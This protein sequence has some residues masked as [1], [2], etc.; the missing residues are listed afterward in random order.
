MSARRAL[1]DETELASLPVSNAAPR[2]AL[3]EPVAD[4]MTTT[5]VLPK[6]EDAGTAFKRP[7]VSA[8]VM[9]NRALA[10]VGIATAGVLMLPNL[11]G[12]VHAEYATAAKPPAEVQTYDDPVIDVSVADA[13]AEWDAARIAE[14]QKAAAEK[15]AAEKAAAEKAAAEK[16]AAEKAAAEQAAAEQ[17]AAQ[18]AAA[19]RA[20]AQRAA[21]E[22]AA[23]QRAAAQEAASQQA[24]APKPT[25]PAK[26]PVAASGDKSAAISF[27]LAQVGKPYIWG[28]TGPA[29]YDCSGLMVAAFRQAGINLPRTSYDMAGVGTPV[30]SVADLQPGDL[31]I[32]YGGGHA[33]MY[34]GNGQVVESLNENTG[35]IIS[36]LASEPIMAMRHLG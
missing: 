35:V 29:G 5:A 11:T 20:A 16:A 12:V 27:A 4:V 28:S 13:A 23:A 30:T 24:P 8:R 10:F 17:A 19:Q 6:F 32:A 9:R 36:S 15:A 34:I 31:I 1:L 33:A 25:S 21:A 3:Y 14:E 26:T 22:Q 18:Q 2:R 7:V